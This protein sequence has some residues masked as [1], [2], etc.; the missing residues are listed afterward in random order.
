[1]P[2]QK[3]II[4]IA[5]IIDFQEAEMLLKAGVTHL[6]FPF[7]LDVH[8]EDL[9]E[10]D[11]ARIIRDLKIS[12]RAVLITYLKRSAEII[13]LAEYLGCKYVQ[14]H[15]SVDIEQLSDL[16][17]GRPNL[18][19]WKSLVI[20]KNNFDQLIKS[21][22]CYNPY[23]DAFITDTYD[24]VSGA[25]GATG[26]THDWEI[27]KK[28]VELSR[29]PVILAGGLNPGN[30]QEAILKVR[31]FGVDAHTGLEDAQGRKDFDKVQSFVANATFI[32]QPKMINSITP[33]KRV[34]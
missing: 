6:G 1:M 11:A 12:D 29:K 33:A 34:I 13:K 20:R 27:S 28:L 17:S 15:G 2:G 25:S 18:N 14:L 5:G 10:A 3:H 26:K 19:I 16:K 7:R 32:F 31:P 21:V 24:P 8:Q 9:S 23:V 30:V 4:Q 22:H